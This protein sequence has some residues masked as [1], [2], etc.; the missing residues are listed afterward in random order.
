MAVVG[1]SVYLWLRAK[2]RAGYSAAS[3]NFCK[4]LAMEGKLRD[5]NRIFDEPCVECAEVAES[6]QVSAIS[7]LT[8][9][10]IQETNSAK[11]ADLQAQIADY[12]N[13][14]ALLKRRAAE[15]SSVSGYF[16]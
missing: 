12:P 10:S 9:L 5:V 11:R 15:S 13:Q 14:L 2:D 6:S 16:V 3:C 1:A 4:K 7:N 8:Q